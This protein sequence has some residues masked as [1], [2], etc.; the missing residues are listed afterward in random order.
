MRKMNVFIVVC[1]LAFSWIMSASALASVTTENCPDYSFSVPYNESITQEIV[2]QV[3]TEAQACASAKVDRNFIL[4]L[5][6]E[7]LQATEQKESKYKVSN[8]YGSGI[9]NISGVDEIFSV[10][11]TL[12]NVAIGTNVEGLIGNLT[13]E[14][15]E[16][17]FIVIT[18]HAIPE[19]S[20]LLAYVSAGFVTYNT[21]PQV[22]IFGDWFDGINTLTESFCDYQNATAITQEAYLEETKIEGSPN[23]LDS[24]DARE[25]GTNTQL[26]A[27]KSNG[28]TDSDGTEY[29][30]ATLSLYT[31][32][33]IVTGHVREFGVKIN[34]NLA[35]ARNYAF[36]E[37]NLQVG[38]VMATSGMVEIISENSGMEFNRVD[39]ESSSSSV[40]LHVPLEYLDTIGKVF[41]FFPVDITLTLSSIDAQMLKYNGSNRYNR[42]KWKYNCSHNINYG[43]DGPIESANGYAGRAVGQWLDDQ[44]VPTAYKF[45]SN[46]Y[47]TFSYNSVAYITGSSI[48]GTFTVPVNNV[49]THVVVVP[50][51]Y[52][53]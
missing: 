48:T 43:T 52:N 21:D 32:V 7:G 47:I 39:P 53:N 23:Q 50:I 29:D 10:K 19:T 14:T 15:S 24:A 1:L 34:A 12:L 2:P 41:E 45:I 35:N 6:N 31:P 28:M 25:L 13:G 16:G 11:G 49:F 5:Y 22:L 26:R 44:T 17:T 40:T 30:I 18:V 27:Y 46:G 3:K 42:A 33:E 36:N 51:S 4:N 37:Y 38:N 8:Y 20:K 9:I